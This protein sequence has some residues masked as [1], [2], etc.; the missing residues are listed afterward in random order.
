LAQIFETVN[1]APSAGNLQA[2]KVRVVR[3]TERRMAL[4]KAAYDQ[5]FVAEAPVSLVF[6]TDPSRSAERYGKREAELYSV[7][8]ATIGFPHTD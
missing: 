1:L 8:D 2:Y 5:K 4:A 7:L 6:G 3:D